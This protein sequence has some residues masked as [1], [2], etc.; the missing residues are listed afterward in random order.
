RALAAAVIP[1]E[2]ILALAAWLV[3]WLLQFLEM[4][5]ALPGA[6]WQQHA[7]A[8]WTVAIALAG[9]VWILAPR[10]FPGRASGL[11]LLAPAFLRPP[12]APAPGEAWITAF[13]VGQG[14]AIMVRTT[15]RTILYDAGPAF[16][17]EADSGGRILVPELRAAGTTHLDLMVLTHE[18]ADHIGGALS[19]LES[20]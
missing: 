1:L 5:A 4:C 8:P 20:I 15:S 16:G 6:L 7:P 3:E 12:A 19:V 13:D 17:A 11:A 18:D 2:A 10:G 14:L 9:V